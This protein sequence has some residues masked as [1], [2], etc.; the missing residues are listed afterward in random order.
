[1][2]II[3]W[4]SKASERREAKQESAQRNVG[5]C[6]TGASKALI[7]TSWASQGN[8]KG[9]YWATGATV[10]SPKLMA[11]WGFARKRK[12]KQGGPTVFIFFENSSVQI[13]GLH[14][15]FIFRPHFL[16]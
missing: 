12:A 9:K 7:Y 8:P 1:M 6:K 15:L 11:L 14:G 2:H 16:R 10:I 13:F 5:G 3:I 4:F